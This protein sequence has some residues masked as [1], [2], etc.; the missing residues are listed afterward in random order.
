MPRYP[1]VLRSVA[2]NHNSGVRFSDGAPKKTMKFKQYI[3]LRS[4]L[5]MSPGKLVAQGAHASVA[6]VNQ[7]PFKWIEDW[8]NEGTAKIVIRI[9]SEKELMELF[10]RIQYATNNIAVMI[11][12]AGKT[13]IPDSFTAFAVGPY[14]IG[15]KIGEDIQQILG[16][17]PLM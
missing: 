9:N 6:A 13:E 8:T 3:V 16:K 4:D 10:G 17:L 15:E 12:D 2:S 5:D 11:Y 7:V 1:S 14:P